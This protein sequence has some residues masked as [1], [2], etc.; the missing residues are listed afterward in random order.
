MR[1][2]LLGKPAVLLMLAA[3]PA[4]AQPVP[5][6]RI[7][8]RTEPA[9]RTQIV[10][11]GW[12]CFEDHGVALVAGEAAYLDFVGL[13]SVGWRVVGPRGQIVVTESEAFR[14]PEEA[15]QPVPDTR[16]RHIVRYGT[17]G[18]T[19]Y[20]IWSV[21][22]IAG[23]QPVPAVDV[24]GPGLTGGAADL[25]FLRRIEPRP[26]PANCRLRVLRMRFDGE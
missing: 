26:Q 17:P 22:R 24:K 20:M 6:T 13:H 11:P 1:R 25:A 21:I 7:A 16:G 2:L 15:G 19:R 12:I 5:P 9:E 10:G 18:A 14:I 23:P 4:A 3:I 8:G